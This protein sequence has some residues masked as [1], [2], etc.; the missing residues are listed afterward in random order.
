MR[1]VTQTTDG[2]TARSARTREAVVTAV[3][4]LVRNDNIRPTAKEIAAQAGISLRSVYVH[5]DDLDDLFA[6]A[7]ARQA[8]EVAHLLY[9]VDAG[10]P[11]AARIDAVIRQRAA[12]W[13]VL[14]PVRRAAMLWSSR[15]VALREG[16]ERATL[17]AVGDL[18]R[19]FA[20]ELEAWGD[21]R[22]G[23]LEALHVATS[24]GAWDVLRTERCLSVEQ[25]C[26]VVA[27]TL[28]NLLAGPAA[29]TKTNSPSLSG[30]A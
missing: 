23:A 27:I 12:I 17:R 5:F 4:E 15:S 30:K 6:A 9:A 22:D 25:A 1:G 24:A 2:R 18:A 28:A 8:D 14:A 3:L 11:L 16:A 10:L 29:A 13:E 21:G 19:V 26:E 20:T 7:G